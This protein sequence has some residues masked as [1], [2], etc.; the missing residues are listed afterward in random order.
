MTCL[1]V[2][3]LPQLCAFSEGL[4]D[5][6][7][8]YRTESYERQRQGDFAGAMA[9][10]QQAAALDPTYPTPHNDMG[11]LYEQM[12]QLEDAKRA[13]EQALVI[14]PE[15][16]EA[17]ANLAM[18]YERLGD[19]EQAVMHWF[20]RH[21]LGEPSDPWTARAEERLVA[22]GAIDSYPGLK[23][24]IYSRR[25]VIEQEFEAHEQS[26]EEFHTVTEQ[27]KRWP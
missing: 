8:T 2:L 11:I 22:L 26:R 23:G 10:Y 14:D 19:K 6:A 16:L 18:L 3:V 12:G 27:N 24:K 7:V 17:H 20:K 25:H 15:H 5:Q 13:Y 21:Q 4:R 9:G 1:F